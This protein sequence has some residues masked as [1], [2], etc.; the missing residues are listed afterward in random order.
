M[1]KPRLPPRPDPCPATHGGLT[2]NFDVDHHEQYGSLHTHTDTD[3]ITQWD[4]QGHHTH[5]R[6]HTPAAQYRKL[7][8][9]CATCGN[10]KPTRR[11]VY[12]P[13]CLPE[14]TKKRAARARDRRRAAVR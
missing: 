1:T 13:A 5:T 9:G 3:G 8:P 10:P 14:E 2:C 6:W 11:H 4:N 12:C 7:P